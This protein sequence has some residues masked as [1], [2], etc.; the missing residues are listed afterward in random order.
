MRE[1]PVKRVFPSHGPVFDHYVDRI[2]QLK[3]HHR[4]RLAA[5]KQVVAEQGGATAYD[6]CGQMFG[7][8][9]SIH[10]LRFALSETLA[11]LEYLRMCGDLTSEERIG[12]I[13][14]L[15]GQV[16]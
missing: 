4:V 11:H 2:D 7:R 14:Y 10:N 16:E 6:V 8:D 15:V 3:E 13:V 5:M 9:I 12:R 1:L